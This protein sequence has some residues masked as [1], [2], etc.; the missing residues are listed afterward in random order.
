MP[1]LGAIVWRR[2]ERDGFI[3]PR[4]VTF[5]KY[6]RKGAPAVVEP[7]RK[8][9]KIYRLTAYWDDIEGARPISLFSDAFVAVASDGSVR[10]LKTLTQSRR[11]VLCQTT[12]HRNRGIVGK[13]KE[14]VSLPTRS[15]GF[16]AWH[17]GWA[18]GHD[19]TPE[20]H[21]PDVFRIC[22]HWW[23]WSVEG[24]MTRVAARKS[25]ETAAFSVD[26]ER[27]PYFFT[28]RDGKAGGRKIFHIVRT[29][30]RQTGNRTTQIK[31][32]FRGQR[33]FTWNGYDVLIS[34]P[35]W[36]HHSQYDF[37]LGAY[38]E[39]RAPKSERLVQAAPEL[40]KHHRRLE[41]VRESR[42]NRVKPHA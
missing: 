2:D 36:H 34:V 39:E 37:N 22:A 35:G 1:A 10:A 13:G 24:S 20:E 31:M 16:D 25:G 12:R 7:T 18:K 32:H 3:C 38:D 21:L 5:V 27:T 29:H 30:E 23:E 6:K 9:E 26:I 40:E 33:H 41:D 4:I 19:K 17:T 8:G 42:K 28:D 15:W 14:W 11:Q